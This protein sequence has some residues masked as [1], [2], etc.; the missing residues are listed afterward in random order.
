M[1]L[2]ADLH[3]VA[4]EKL[5]DAELLDGLL[6]QAAT[7]AGATILHSHFHG[8][9][10]GLGITGVLLLAESHISAH[11]WPELGY[12]A[13][14]IFMCGDSQPD[15][16]LQVLVSALAPQRHAVRRIRRPEPSSTM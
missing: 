14:D 13:L 10:P 9:G 8:F 12:A 6:R 5:S 1:H 15:E 16:A 2:L 7:A 11:T 4:A 3:G